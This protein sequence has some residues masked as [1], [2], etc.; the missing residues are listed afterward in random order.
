MAGACPSQTLHEPMMTW[1]VFKMTTCAAANDERL[2][3][4]TFLAQCIQCNFVILC[5]I[6]F[7]SQ[8]NTKTVTFSTTGHVITSLALWQ[9]WAERRACYLILL[10]LDKQPRYLCL[11]RAY[12]SSPLEERNILFDRKLNLTYITMNDWFAHTTTDS[13]FVFRKKIVNGIVDT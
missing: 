1:K 4:M 9:G 6:C 2:V 12:I 8:V 3:K 10:M 13:Y 5:T 11:Q 7:C